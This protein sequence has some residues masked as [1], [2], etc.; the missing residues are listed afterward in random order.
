MLWGSVAWVL[1]W[2]GTI[3]SHDT[4]CFGISL[5]FS[6][7]FL[8]PSELLE[9]QIEYV[10]YRIICGYVTCLLEW[11]G[12]IGSHDTTCFGISLPFSDSFLDPSELLEIQIEYVLY[13]IICGYVTCL[14]EWHGSI[15]SHDTTCFGIS[16]PLSGSFLDPSKLLEIQIE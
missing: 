13:R 3:G 16:L 7:S 14:L 6:G 4:T 1:E 5:P 10:V 11:H 15:G 8:D 2:H 12:S 9:I